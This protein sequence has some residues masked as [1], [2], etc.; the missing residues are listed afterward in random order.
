M[1]R[2]SMDGSSIDRSRKILISAVVC[3][4][5]EEEHLSSCLDSL[6][7]QKTRLSYEVIVIDDG[8]TDGTRTIAMDWAR[9][10]GGVAVRH[11]QIVHGGLSVARNTGVDRSRGEIVAFVDADA[12]AEPTWLE[13][14]A[15]P[16][17]DP[18]VDVVAGRVSNLDDRQRFSRFIHRVH[19]EAV[20]R[21][22]K[23]S[24][25]TGANMAFRKNIFESEGIGFFDYFDRRGDETSLRVR[26]FG[27]NPSRKL[28]SAP[29][30]VV[31][32]QHPDRFFTW[33]SQQSYEGAMTA[34]I[35]SCIDEHI[36]RAE[37]IAK[38]LV[39]SGALAA[40]PIALLAAQDLPLLAVL[41]LAFWGA[42]MA[43]RAR[44]I[45]ESMRGGVES[46]GPLGA[47]AALGV[48]LTGTMARDL[49]YLRAVPLLLLGK[50]IDMGQSV[51]SVVA[52]WDD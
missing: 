28:V 2:S 46:E 36:K 25:L 12:R 13:N 14:I 17:S 31:H 21:A 24:G 19:F 43:F 8:S 6:A 10:N 9:R 30:A 33:L 35:E 22:M 41:A 32:N 42:R 44:Y 48:V 15:G 52:S 38:L 26:Y 3:A 4:F 40:L 5:N 27:R 1:N 23:D 45:L 51:G 47:I 20:M 29:D 18:A 16:F 39:R 37:I 11:F 49:G 7:A 50:K 34:V